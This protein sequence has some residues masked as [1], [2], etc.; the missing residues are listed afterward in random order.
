MSTCHDTTHGVVDYQEFERSPDP[1]PSRALSEQEVELVTGYVE[2]A[3]ALLQRY[4]LI[5]STHGD[6]PAVLDALF[7]RWLDDSTP[8]RPS[9]E[10]VCLSLGSAFGSYFVRTKQMK[11]RIAQ[12]NDEEVTLAVVHEASQI[13]V[14][15][16]ASVQKRIYSRATGFFE[17]IAILVCSKFK[18]EQH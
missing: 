7:A 1:T 6:S 5:E 16:I 9:E 17:A 2:H 11:W 12:V 10:L 14:Y 18:P 8:D 15:P 3:G 13:A 4:S